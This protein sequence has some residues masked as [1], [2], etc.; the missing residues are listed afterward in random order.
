M[1]NGRLRLLRLEA[2]LAPAW[3]AGEGLHELL[4]VAAQ[5]DLA[6]TPVDITSPLGRLLAEPWE[7]DAP[8]EVGAR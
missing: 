3:M 4:E 5:F 6:D 8:P 2:A 1:R 7:D